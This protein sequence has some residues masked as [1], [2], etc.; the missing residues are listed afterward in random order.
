MPTPL[1]LILTLIVAVNI[2]GCAHQ[3][4]NCDWGCQQILSRGPYTDPTVT[5]KPEQRLYYQGQYTGY[6]LR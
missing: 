2:Q 4:P 3:N 5:V 1:T 6:S